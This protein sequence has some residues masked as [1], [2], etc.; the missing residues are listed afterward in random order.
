MSYVQLMIQIKTH[1]VMQ[2]DGVQFNVQGQLRQCHGTLVNV[3]ADNPAACLIGGFKQF[4]SALRKC[5]HCM[6]VDDGI[7]R[8]VILNM[9][10]HDLSKCTKTV[11]GKLLWLLYNLLKKL[12]SCS[13]NHKK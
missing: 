2:D 1:Y 13:W 8:K 9:H 12:Y 11:N 6:A 4:H 5:R 7:Q 10:M 3:S